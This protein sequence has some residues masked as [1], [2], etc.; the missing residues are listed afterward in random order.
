MLFNSVPINQSMSIVIYERGIIYNSVP[1][2]MCVLAVNFQW[3]LQAPVPLSAFFF[4]PCFFFKMCMGVLFACMTMHS[5]HAGPMGL[6][7]GIQSSGTGVTD[8]CPARVG[9]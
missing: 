3:C 6:E 7:E 5:S 8:S 4:F 9:I 2:Y 1:A